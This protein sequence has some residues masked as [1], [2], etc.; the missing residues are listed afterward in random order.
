MSARN[1]DRSD[2]HELFLE[3]VAGAE[4]LPDRERRQAPAAPPAPVAVKRPS[5]FQIDRDG[6]RVLGRNHG[7]SRSQVKKLATDCQPRSHIDLHRHTADNARLRLASF[8]RNATSDCVLVITGKGTHS[9]GGSVLKGLVER[10]L[11]GPLADRVRAFSTAA[12]RDGGDGA[13]YV[14]LKD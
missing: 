14:W 12:G 8:V 3:A 2:D 9:D 11:S 7:V 10:E 1:V 4:P 5:S 13:Y 6:A